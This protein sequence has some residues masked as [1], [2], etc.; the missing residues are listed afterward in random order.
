MLQEACPWDQIT[1]AVVLAPGEAIL[2]FGRCSQREGLPYRSAKDV[3]FSLRGPVNWAGRTAQMEATANTVQEGD[4]A[5]V[6]AVMEKKTKARGPGCPQGLRRAIQSW[7]STCNIS[8]WMWGL[9]EGASDGEVRRTSDA[10]AQCIGG[11]GRWHW[12]QRTP[13]ILRGSPGGSTSSGG[14]ISDGGSDWSSLHLTVTRASSSSH[15]SVLVRRGL[16]MVNLAI[17]KD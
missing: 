8:D 9:D 5:I 4:W 15:R 6:D 2:F 14:E 16:W 17:F 1:K 10:L 3:E 11:G 12:Q 7:T 13:G